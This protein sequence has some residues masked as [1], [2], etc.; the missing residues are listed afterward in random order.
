MKGA[1][2]TISAVLSEADTRLEQGHELLL[3]HSPYGVILFE[4]FPLAKI[5][6]GDPDRKMA[7]NVR[8]TSSALLLLTWPATEEARAIFKTTAPGIANTLARAMEDPNA[9]N[10]ANYDC[11]EWLG[12]QTLLLTNP[13]CRSH[14]GK[15]QGR[16]RREIPATS[17][18][19]G[20]V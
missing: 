3:Q 19:Q 18:A 10:Y 2:V 14:G 7:F 12:W 11:G 16:L 8:D 13:Y 6:S 20:E 5:Q 15:G 17:A 4:L 9:P 1:G